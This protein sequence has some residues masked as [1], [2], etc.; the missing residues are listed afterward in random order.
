MERKK[1]LKQRYK[2]TPK[3]AGVYQIKNNKKQKIFIKST[4]DLKTMNGQQFQ[5]EFG[6]HQNKLLQAEW[7]KFGKEAFTFEVLEVLKRQENE[8]LD[9]KD[10]LK[11]LEEKWINKLSPFGE[12]GYN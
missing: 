1:E 9:A 4:M 8:T 10:A 2:E 6:S 5:L 11:K 3:A 12:R 7:K